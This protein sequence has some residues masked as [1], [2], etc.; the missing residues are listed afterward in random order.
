MKAYTKSIEALIGQLVKMPGIGQ[1][2]A[3]RLVFYILKISPAQVEQLA[4]SI[5]RLKNSVGYCSICYN[6]SEEKV[7]R[8]CSDPH[9]DRSVVCVVGQPHDVSA[10]EKSGQFKG[11]Y[12]VLLGAISPL[13]GVGPEKL[14]IAELIRRVKKGGVKEVIIA[15]DYDT[16]G[17]ATALYLIQVLRPLKVKLSR[18]ASGIPLGGNIEYADQATLARALKDRKET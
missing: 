9:R 11:V 14:K 17:E 4:S 7:C 15:S 13:D 8:I 5:S 6:L 10:I 3:E 12:H 16:E 18:I 2:S 1:R